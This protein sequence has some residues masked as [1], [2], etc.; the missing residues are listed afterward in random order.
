MAN[1]LF[2]VY[3]NG[4]E[5]NS[6]EDVDEWHKKRFPVKDVLA[7]IDMNA[8]SVWKELSDEEKKS[9]S[10][11]LL[12][13]YVSAVKGTEKHKS[14]QYLKLTNIIIN[15]LTTLVLAKTT[16]IQS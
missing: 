7:A 12:N 1:W 9:V 11:W 3:Y 16:G 2:S 13:R 4:V 14:L 15:T 8:K 10:F 5:I 6:P